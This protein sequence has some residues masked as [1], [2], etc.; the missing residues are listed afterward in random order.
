MLPGA[1][2]TPFLHTNPNVDSGNENIDPREFGTVDNVA[3]AIAFLAS[4]EARFVQG[5][6]LVVDGGRTCYL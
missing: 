6:T 4:D 5:A 2:E 1:I 3:A